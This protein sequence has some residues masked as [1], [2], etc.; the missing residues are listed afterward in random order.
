MSIEVAV[1]ISIISV[2]FSV[3]F[4]LKNNKRSDTKDIETRVRE[5]TT[6]N[7]K[8]DNITSATQEIKAEIV[9]VREDI[10][11]HN[12]RLIKVEESAKQ[13]HHRINGIEDRIKGRDIKE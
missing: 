3:F 9:P 11:Q 1:L 10:K 5:N 6:I 8:L 7:L 13:A 2:S 12:D 4:G